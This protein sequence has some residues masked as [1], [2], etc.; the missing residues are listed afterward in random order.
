[1]T[2][3]TEPAI[4][5]AAGI[6]FSQPGRIVH[7][8]RCHSLVQGWITNPATNNGI[9]LSAGTAVVQ[10]DSKENDQT[11]HPATLD[12]DLVDA[13]PTGATGPQGPQG[14]AGATGATGAAGL[15]GL[16][17]AIKARRG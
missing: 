8:Y 15:A 7:C 16:D 4:G 10:F 14:P 6:V 1:M 5:S 9:A 3:A 2:Y 12:I 13:G 11:S 17:G